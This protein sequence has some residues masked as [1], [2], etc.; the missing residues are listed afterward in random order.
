MVGTAIRARGQDVA[1][2]EKLLPNYSVSILLVWVTRLLTALAYTQIVSVSS[3]ISGIV[4]SSG[5]SHRAA[6]SPMGM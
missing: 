2:E 4:V 3:Y 5:F 6:A 1:L